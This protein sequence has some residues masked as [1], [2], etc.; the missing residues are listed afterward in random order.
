MNTLIKDIDDKIEAYNIEKANINFGI[1]RLQSAREILCGEVLPG[2]PTG[3]VGA[4][5]LTPDEA[6]GCAGPTPKHEESAKREDPGCTARSTSALVKLKAYRDRL[7]LGYAAHTVM[8]HIVEVVANGT[9]D[10]TEPV[11]RPLLTTNLISLGLSR[12]VVYKTLR[13]LE[14]ANVITYSLTRSVDGR[15]ADF[16]D[17]AGAS[18][19][20]M[21]SA[22]AGDYVKRTPDDVYSCIEDIEGR[23]VKASVSTIL[24][25]LYWP[26]K[27]QIY[28]S[29]VA[30]VNDKRIAN[31]PRAGGAGYYVTMEQ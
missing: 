12:A 8:V 30:L 23:G 25:N 5:T 15:A 14:E 20:Y 7:P 31:V 9:L 11:N 22:E 29:I 28:A 13:N 18:S 1:A 19:N 16:C 26:R 27:S 3:Y 2:E 21:L 10:I 6:G 24:D 4:L 17:V